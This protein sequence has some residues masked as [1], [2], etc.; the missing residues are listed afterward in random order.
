[1]KLN[2]LY[3]AIWSMFLAL[4]PCSCANDSEDSDNP[5]TAAENYLMPH[6]SWGAGSDEIKDKQNEEYF[7]TTLSDG[8]LLFEHSGED[9]IILSYK[10]NDNNELEASSVMMLNE[11]NNSGKIK[12]LL[13]SFKYVGERNLYQIYSNTSI[14]TAAM[15]MTGKGDNGKEYISLCF[16]SYVP[17]TE[18]DDE[19]LPYVDLG[20]SVKWAK[21][22]LGASSPD[23]EG[24]FYSW[25]ETKIKSE[26]WRENYSYCNN[27]ANQYIFVYSNP[28]TNISGTKYDVATSKLGEG[29]RMPTRDEA[30]E[31]I[32]G[33][34]WKQETRNGVVGAKITGPTGKSIFIPNTG[35]K[36]QDKEPS[37]LTHIW[38]SETQSKSN[39]Y[40]YTIQTSANKNTEPQL[41]TIWK[42][43]GLQV[44]AVYDK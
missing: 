7:L 23:G 19:N 14:N 38:T 42:A 44:R 21:C 6:I 40:A 35:F 24:S 33:C 22:N 26:Y 4:V 28:L 34:T 27:N 15:F 37:G 16:S 12:G 1:M 10:F 17:S 41:E 9:D 43:W 5:V 39:E 3:I 31:L 2:Q 13:R 11:N 20:L 30:F 36:K 29:W 18:E 32:Y 8:T 25:S